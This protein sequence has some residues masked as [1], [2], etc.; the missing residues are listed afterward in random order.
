MSELLRAAWAIARSGWRAAW[1]RSFRF[2]KMKTA[3][4]ALVI[5]LVFVLFIARRSPAL[6]GGSTNG[7]AGMLALFAVQMGWF[8]LMQGFTRGQFQLY[9]GILVPLFQMSPTRPLAFLLGRVIEAVPQRIWSC[10]LWGW[11]YSGVVEGPARW[12]AALLLAALGLG[13]GMVAHLSGLL[14]LAFWSYYSPKTMRNG[15]IF[16]GAVT[17]A[18]ATWAVIFLAQGGTMT[19]LALTM[20]AYRMPVLA[21]VLGLA[22]VPG[23]L[24]LGAMAVRPEAVENL[25]RQGVYRVIELGETEAVRPGRSYWLPIG[26]GVFRAVLSRE[27]LQL[28]RNRITRVQLLIWVAGTVGVWFA[29]RAIAGEGLERVIQYVG[30]LSLLTW[31][32]A[33]GHWVVRVFEL[34]RKTVLLYRLAA[35]STPRLLAAK[36]TSVFTP[37]LILV[38]LGTVVGS[39]AA[40]LNLADTLE[41][42]A[43]TAGALA[44]GTIGGFGAAAATAGEE[45][46]EQDAAGAP[47]QADGPPQ[48]TGNAWWSLARTVALVITMGLPIWTGAGQPWLPFRLPPLLLW[49]ANLLLPLGLLAFGAQLMIRTWER[50][51]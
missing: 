12:G 15:L 11:A 23:V 5:Q 35:V 4:I 14:L 38:V 10:L 33:Y 26:T 19:D 36:F 3:V 49:S 41:V 2:S 7:I 43:W 18:L 22:G 34:E 17:L 1:N 6:A 27:W 45:P 13:I 37:S 30:L 28:S 44:L 20:R 24:L 31:F 40:G 9:Q 8:G 46:E 47:R 42:T 51:G 21:A 39:A 16:F 25:Y 48:P 50:N 32:M 29:G